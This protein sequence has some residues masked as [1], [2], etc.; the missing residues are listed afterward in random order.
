MR[1]KTYV[2]Q[3]E[4]KS[5]KM[6]RLGAYRRLSTS[7]RLKDINWSDHEAHYPYRREEIEKMRHGK[8][9]EVHPDMPTFKQLIEEPA[10]PLVTPGTMPD[11]VLRQ[12]F[13]LTSTFTV[14]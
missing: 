6:F 1:W 10:F 9:P 11:I 14:Y 12:V 5:S 2:V 4:V 7:L 3:L 8:T 13:L